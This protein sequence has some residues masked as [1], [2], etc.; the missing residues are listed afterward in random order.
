MFGI[1]PLTSVIQA[2]I[3]GFTFKYGLK[4]FKWLF[5][6][7]MYYMFIFSEGP[8]QSE[9]SKKA[10]WS[11]V[12]YQTLHLVRHNMRVLTAKVIPLK[13]SYFRNVS[14]SEAKDFPPYSEAWLPLNK[15][16]RA[17]LSRGSHDYRRFA[18]TL[19][20]HSRAIN[21]ERKNLKRE[22]ANE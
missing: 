8:S 5:Y 15:Q 13:P 7:F 19:K 21:K 4:V 1:N 18:R 6:I 14:K 20:F 22:L 17:N 2:I 10:G 9:I 12:G 3:A 11:Q 16:M